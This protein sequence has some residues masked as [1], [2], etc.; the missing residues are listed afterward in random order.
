MELSLDLQKFYF[1]CISILFLNFL[2]L[3][4]SELSS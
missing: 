1:I 3:S 2:N 4:S